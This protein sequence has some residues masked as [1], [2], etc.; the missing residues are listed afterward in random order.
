[1]FN[2]QEALLA[3]RTQTWSLVSGVLGSARG[4]NIRNSPAALQSIMQE[5]RGVARAGHGETSQA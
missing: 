4:D 3:V 2:W 5:G 1:M